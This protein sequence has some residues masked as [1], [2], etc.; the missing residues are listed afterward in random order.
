M[1]PSQ[2][3]RGIEATEQ[4]LTL[5]SIILKMR[6]WMFFLWSKK[7]LIILIAF[8]GAAL[9]VTYAFMKDPQ[10]EAELTFVMEESNSNPLGAY[11]GMAS[12][13]GI[14]LSGGGGNSGIF[15]GDNIMV[16]LKSRL[17]IEKTLLSPIEID[18]KK[19]TLV[20]RYIDVNKLRARWQKKPELLKVA[21]P[22]GQERNTFTLLQ[23]SILQTIYTDISKRNLDIDKTA[24][25][26]NFISVKTTTGDQVFSKVFTERLV[27]EAGEFYIDTKTRRV[28]MNLDRLQGQADSIEMFLNRKT[29]NI[30]AARDLNLNPARQVVGVNIEV[31]MRDKMML[32]T[33]YAEVV[34]NLELT[35]ITM[36]QETPIIQIVDT[37][38]YPLKKV[39]LGKLVALIVGGMMGGIVIVF[40]LLIKKILREILEGN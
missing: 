19:I 6:E 38:I 18:S 35:K 27:K 34:K 37:P 33:M 39:K 1:E 17:M 3:S 31:A 30:A 29:Y 9:G 10:Y 40:Y 20:E 8:I 28:K 24:K 23:D 26:Y 16:F 5:K 25:Q 12:Q 36:A 22:Y 4:E 2:R 14:D 32:E 15:Q 21:Y 13:L 7:F 11:A